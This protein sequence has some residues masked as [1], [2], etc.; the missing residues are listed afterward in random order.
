M[1]F[2]SSGG[3]LY[4]L[5]FILQVRFYSSGES[6][7]LRWSMPRCGY[8][9][10][11]APSAG[12]VPVATFAGPCA[13]S[14]AGAGA[15]AGARAGAAARSA[16]DAS[17]A[18][19]ER[20]PALARRPCWP[21][22]AAPTT[23]GAALCRRRGGRQRGRAVPAGREIEAGREV[24]RQYIM[25]HGY[26][27]EGGPEFRDVN[28]MGVAHGTD[29]EKVLAHKAAIDVHLAEAGIEVGYT[30]VFWG[31]RSEIKPSEISPFAYPV[32]YTHLTLPTKAE[33]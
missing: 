33:V 19:S 24:G 2:Y 13:R 26:R 14:F 17:R 32:S 22:R 25:T 1:R 28:V 3:L 20:G 21:P 6:L 23:A 29:K 7:A 27:R 18:A 4:T 8:E 10:I 5:Y 16:L 9:P 31:G 15:G 12:G 30:N 11:A